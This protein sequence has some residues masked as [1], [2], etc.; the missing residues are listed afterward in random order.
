MLKKMQ[1]IEFI[2]ASLSY[3]VIK[4]PTAVSFFSALS[5]PKQK[6]LNG[7]IKRRKSRAW[8]AV[9]KTINKLKKEEERTKDKKSYWTIVKYV[10]CLPVN[11]QTNR[12]M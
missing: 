11:V 10:K 7:E 12:P 9:I 4:A 6:K 3:V 5:R 8:K 1:K 2:C